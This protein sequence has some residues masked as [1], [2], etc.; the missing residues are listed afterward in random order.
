MARWRVQDQAWREES[1]GGNEVFM[2]KRL[3]W[4]CLGGDVLLGRCNCA[5]N[6][7]IILIIH[8]ALGKRDRVIYGGYGILEEQKGQ[9]YLCIEVILDPATYCSLYL[10]DDDMIRRGR[11]SKYHTS[12]LNYAIL[13]T[14]CKIGMFR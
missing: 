8:L 10:G 3:V 6:S 13:P 9:Y 1:H 7:C 4:L 2:L 11:K 5:K 14:M 12:L